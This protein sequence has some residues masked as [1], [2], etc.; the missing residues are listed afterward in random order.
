MIFQKRYQLGIQFLSKFER[1]ECVRI[2]MQIQPTQKATRLISD[3]ILL[4]IIGCEDEQTDQKEKYIFPLSI[5][6]RWEYR[7]EYIYTS[8]DTTQTDTIEI[9][10]GYDSCS[11]IVVLEAIL[12]DKIETVQL[13]E[14]AWEDSNIV[15]GLYYYQERDTG[16]FLI[17]YQNPY[18]FALPKYS[19]S[20]YFYGEPLIPDY[21]KRFFFKEISQ[22]KKTSE[23]GKLHFEDPPVFVLKYPLEIGNYWTYRQEDQPFRIDKEVIQDTSITVPAGTFNCYQIR[24][25]YDYAEPFKNLTIHFYDFIADE[26]LILRK[27]Y[28]EAVTH[29]YDELRYSKLNDEYK[30][31]D[32]EIR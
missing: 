8:F 10:S 32:Y 11:V 18:L 1:S 3:I 31:M 2:T 6:N 17:A 19:N 24:W 5:W 26:G 28:I 12:L 15:V 25:I 7:R 14:Q 21:L 27:I 22:I 9:I 23:N 16:L 4:I 20:L 13:M 30:L 29:I